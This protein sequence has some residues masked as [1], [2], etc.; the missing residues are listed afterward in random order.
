MLTWR[1][2]SAR[3]EAG[4]DD[5]LAGGGGRAGAHVP[6]RRA[7]LDAGPL[8]GAVLSACVMGSIRSQ[9]QGAG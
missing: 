8:A 1:V 3:T 6:A 5:R 7:R 4:A 2:G 9:N